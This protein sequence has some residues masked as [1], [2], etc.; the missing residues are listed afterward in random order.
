MLTRDVQETTLEVEPLEQGESIEEMLRR[1]T[2]NNEPIPAN[3]QEIFTPRENGVMPEY[4]IRADR[5]DMAIEATDKFAASKQA[6]SAE[7]AAEESAG[8][9]ES[10]ENDNGGE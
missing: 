6:M 9:Q 7:S 5:F 4:D 10:Y 1:L 3:V 8:G 2:A